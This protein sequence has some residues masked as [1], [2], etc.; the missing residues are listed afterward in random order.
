MKIVHVYGRTYDC[1]EGEGWENHTRI[2]VDHSYR[3]NGRIY[4]VAGESLNHK[5]QQAIRKGLVL[6]QHYQTV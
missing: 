6:N 2:E 3:D 1:F 4:R 5:Q